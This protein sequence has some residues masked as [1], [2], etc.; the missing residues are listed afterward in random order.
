[1]CG[2][3]TGNPLGFHDPTHLTTISPY[4]WEEAEKTAL[5]R[6]KFKLEREKHMGGKEVVRYSPWS[7][8]YATKKAA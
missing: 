6:E 4:Q 3:A 8:V 1:V 2:S 5:E 7:P